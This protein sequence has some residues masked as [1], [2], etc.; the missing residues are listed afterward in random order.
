MGS[1][2]I[3]FSLATSVWLSTLY[4]FLGWLCLKYNWNIHIIQWAIFPVIAYGISLGMNSIAQVITC[5]KVSLPKLALTSLFVPGFILVAFLL[6]LV[7]F[8]R[9]PIEVVISPSS[10]PLYGSIFAISFYVFWATM[11]GEAISIGTA[12]DCS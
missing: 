12:T 4:F 6:T 2:N 10:R 5:Q 1:V 8:I 9:S 3:G 7:S 11:F